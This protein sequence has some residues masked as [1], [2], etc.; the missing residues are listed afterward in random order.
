[1]TNSSANNTTGAA[2]LFHMLESN[3]LRDVEETKKVF[4]DHFLQ[5]KYFYSNSSI[6]IIEFIP[7][8]DN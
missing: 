2:E 3:K 8:H 6:N 5:S 7:L 1:M 4:H